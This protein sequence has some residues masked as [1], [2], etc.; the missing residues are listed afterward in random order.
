[1]LLW[2]YSNHTVNITAKVTL[3]TSEAGYVVVNTVGTKVGHGVNIAG[4]SLISRTV[5]VDVKHHVY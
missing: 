2:L 1:M 3:S 5:S 4:P